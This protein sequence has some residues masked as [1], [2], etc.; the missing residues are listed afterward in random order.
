MMDLT[1]NE[2]QRMMADDD[3]LN[4]EEEKVSKPKRTIPRRRKRRHRRKPEKTPEELEEEARLKH[5]QER[6]KTKE[7]FF[8]RKKVRG[9]RRLETRIYATLVVDSNIGTSLSIMLQYMETFRLIDADGGGS[10]DIDEIREAFTMMGLNAS[11]QALNAIF[12]KYGKNPEEDSLDIDEFADAMAQIENE[13]SGGDAEATNTTTTATALVPVLSKA[14]MTRREE[15][16]KSLSEVKVPFSMMATSFKRLSL[17]DCAV[18]RISSIRVR[19][20]A[21]EIRVPF[22]FQIYITLSFIF[23]LGSQRAGRTDRV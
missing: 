13:L 7:R 8:Q 20:R 23:N 1:L 9:C 19:R 22:W 12:D 16:E 21:N 14:V 6:R 3:L 5:E 2:G 10:L 11:D 17:L 15:E 18:H 4:Q